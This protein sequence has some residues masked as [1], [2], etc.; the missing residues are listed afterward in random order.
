MVELVEKKENPLKKYYDDIFYNEKE[1]QEKL[2]MIPNR[3]F[4]SLVKKFKYNNEKKA[5]DLGYGAGN[6]SKYLLENNFNVT[7]VDIVD[8]SIFMN[9]CNQEVKEKKLKVIEADINYYR[10]NEK[11]DFMISKDVLHYLKRDNVEKILSNT[12]TITNKNGYH[13]IVIFADINRKDQNGNKSIIE[14]EANYSTEEVIGLVKKY[15]KDWNTNIYIKPYKEKDKLSK[16]VDYYF[17]ANQITIIANKL[18]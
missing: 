5:L 15:Y 1:N 17:Q 2:F 12:T 7:A 14:N 10:S 11:I 18:S 8:K 9:K 16:F 13:Y 3:K 4:K 6:Y